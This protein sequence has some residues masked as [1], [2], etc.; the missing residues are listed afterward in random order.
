MKT[1]LQKLSIT[2]LALGLVACASTGDKPLYYWGN[3]TDMVYTT[4]KADGK[5]S[6]AQQLANI[7]RYFADAEKKNM[8][9]APGSHAY[10]GLILLNNGQTGRALTEFEAEKKLYP[11]SSTFMDYLLRKK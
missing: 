6:P 11:E 2:G 9:V 4:L 7:D 5:V 3:Q 1:G 10:R 8:K